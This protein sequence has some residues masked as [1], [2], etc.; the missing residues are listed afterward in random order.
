AFKTKHSV[1][2]GFLEDYAFLIKAYHSLYQVTFD[3]SYLAKAQHWMEY[4]IENF[5]D[6]QEKYFHFASAKAEKLIAKKKEVFDNVIPS[7]NSVMAQNLFHL[8][9][10]LDKEEWKTLAIDMVKPLIKII[11][12]EPVYMSN[13]GILLS[14]ITNGLHAVVISGKEAKARRKELNKN[15]LPF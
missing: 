12:S 14:E 7:S 8:G 11:A 13:W 3:E 9:T 10:L 15:F 6:A 5:Y 2:E 1:T 4:T